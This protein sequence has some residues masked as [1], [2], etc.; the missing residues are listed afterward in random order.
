MAAFCIA[1]RQE[2][3]RVRAHAGVDRGSKNREGRHRPL[4]F[5][6]GHPHRYPASGLKIRR[7]VMR[8]F[9][10]AATAVLMLALVAALAPARALD[11]CVICDE[12]GNYCHVC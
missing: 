4:K 8:Y 12:Y 7:T 6:A 3:R 10:V 5:L 9:L 2:T 1:E 11:A